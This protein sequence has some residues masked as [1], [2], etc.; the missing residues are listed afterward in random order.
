MSESDSDDESLKSIRP[1]SAMSSFSDNSTGLQVSDCMLRRK[2]NRLHLLS[3][4]R[5]TLKSI[6]PTRLQLHSLSSDNKQWPHG[7][8]HRH[9]TAG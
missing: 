3:M 7:H 2:A 4:G 6:M 8:V 5:R 9:S 1:G